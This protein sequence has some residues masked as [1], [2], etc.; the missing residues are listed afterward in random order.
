MTKTVNAILVDDEE[1]AR[2]V[3]STLL[4]TNCP[5][6]NLMD[7]CKNVKEAVES[8]KK[9]KPD[10]VFL[11]IE[12]PEHAGYEI[13]HFFDE[14]HFEIIFV[15]AYDQYAIKAFEMS[16][17]D[18]LLK[19][20]EIK[21]LKEAVSKLEEKLGSRKLEENYRLLLENMEKESIDKIVIPHNREQ[22]ILP[23][24]KIVAIEAKESYSIIHTNESK[25]YMVS[26]NLKHFE[27]LLE[28][29]SFFRS[30]KSWLINMDKV[31]SYSKKQLEIT[32]EGG[33][34]TKLSKYKKPNFE[35]AFS[36]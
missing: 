5:Q 25:N 29:T 23:L 32:L 36:S 17:L 11:D 24:E 18:Y 12:M 3:L 7:Q 9:N 8:I 15:T 2:N 33:L 19:P 28:D 6:V 16:A 26:R 31:Q 30:H 34:S 4:A 22:V 35:N 14:I 13:I 10:V 27:S 1:R 20:I 21:R